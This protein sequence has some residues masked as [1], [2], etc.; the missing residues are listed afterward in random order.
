LELL[1]GDAPAEIDLFADDD[2]R[3]LTAGIENWMFRIEKFSE[4]NLPCRFRTEN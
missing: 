3:N 4:G 1:L 2:H